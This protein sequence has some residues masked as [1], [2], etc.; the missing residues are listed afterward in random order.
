MCI[1]CHIF[2]LLRAIVTQMLKTLLNQVQYKLLTKTRNDYAG[3]K[4][5]WPR[6]M[7]I[8]IQYS[9]YAV[10]FLEKLS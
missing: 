8:D 3:W 6:V 10:V 7:I 5:F 1:W 9:I 2:S 4:C